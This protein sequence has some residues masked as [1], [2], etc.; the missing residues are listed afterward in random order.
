[1]R[2]LS[3]VAAVV[4]L[5][6]MVGNVRGADLPKIV[7]TVNGVDLTEADLAEEIKNILPTESSFHGGVAPDKMK[8][9]RAK[10]MAA[11]LEIELQY[12]D[13]LAKGQKL[14][15]DD[16]D[17]EIGKLR[18]K[19]RSKGDFTKLIAAAGF[20]IASTSSTCGSRS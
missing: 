14:S 13:A 16:L 8:T 2:F 1:M 18:E 5:T 3:V 6:G 19:F 20:T 9:I 15:D 17:A 7:A 11:L 4:F 12:Q 10:A